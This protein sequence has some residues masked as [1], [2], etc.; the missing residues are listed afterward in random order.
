M[1]KQ[2]YYTLLMWIKV[3]VERKYVSRSVIDGEEEELE[4]GMS[5]DR[6]R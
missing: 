1:T 3:I 4:A 2:T 5:R 6:L